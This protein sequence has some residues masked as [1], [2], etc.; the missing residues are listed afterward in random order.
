MRLEA[1]GM[2]YRAPG[3]GTGYLDCP[4]WLWQDNVPAPPCLTQPRVSLADQEHGLLQERGEWGKGWGQ[5]LGGTSCQAPQHLP[6]A[7]PQ[8]EYCRKAMA[9]TRVKSSICL[10]G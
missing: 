1:T 10:E 2:G 4:G 3:W 5:L 9:R 7:W 8:I 6:C